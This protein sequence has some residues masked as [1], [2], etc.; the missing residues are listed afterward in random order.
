MANNK[1]CHRGQ[2]IHGS[3]QLLPKIHK[4]VLKDCKPNHL[5]SKEGSEIRM[6]S[7]VQREILAT[8]RHIDK[9]TNTK[10]CRS[11]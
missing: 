7:Q 9:Y 11:T 2:I 10:D 1:K 3:F 6:D 4:S 5:F 8:E